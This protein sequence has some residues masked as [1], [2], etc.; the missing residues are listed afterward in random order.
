V[1]GE[2]FAPVPNRGMI[3]ISIMLANIMQGVDNTIL[4]V[5]L[6]HVQG[7]LSASLDQ[8]AWALTSYIV[9]AAIMMP[10]TGWLAGSFGIK[11]IFLVSVIGFTLAS[12]LCGA[13]TNLGELVFFRAL[14][15]VAGAGLVPLSQ[16]ILLQINPP[17]RHGH[18]MAVFGIGTIMGPIMGPAL[19]GWLTYDYSWR[20][21][22][23][24]NLPVGVLCTLGTLIFIRQTGHVHR[25][26]FDFVGF[27][28]LSLGIGAL[29]LMLDRGELKDWFHSSEIWIEATVAGLGF[30]LFTVHTATTGERSFLNRGLLTSA[31][32]VAGTLLMFCAG[33][34]QT[35]TLALLPTMLQTLMN[36]PA[37]TT[38][39]VTMPRG[40]GS[41][42]AM[43]LVAPLI[44][45]VDN[46]LLILFGFL[47]TALSMWQMS[48]FSL[49]MGMAPVII[50]GLL[51]GFGL[52]CTQVPLNI[53]A[54]STLPLHVLTQGTAIRSLMRNLGGS[55][56]I[57]ILVATLAENT[58]IVHARLVE[59]LRPDNP[60]AQAPYLGAPFS[61]STPGGMAALNAEVTRQA[62]M[63]AYIDDFKLIMLIALASI[64]LLLL[65]REARRRPPPAA[66]ATTAAADD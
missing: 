1:R 57:S 33:L 47:L 36:Y 3:T 63:V 44:N 39:L 55:L 18:A 46:R 53:I 23:Y 38:G 17:E 14:Q 41:M 35:G 50:S 26:P 52:G 62:A 64:P 22:F 31:N 56:G 43:F 42:A 28:T 12:A 58:Q 7:S 37:L 19:G 49:E 34:I 27:L 30:Y 2:A 24:I 10:L 60:L 20:W 48:C 59:G 45:R 16:A 11:Y 21:V 65:L 9:C 51:Q 6:P 13:A 40:V 8:V 29:Q 25:E 5:A 15:G 32:F 4:N 66:A 54:L 61:L